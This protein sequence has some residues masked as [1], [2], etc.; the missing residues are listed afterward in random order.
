VLDLRRDEPALLGT[1]LEYLSR[2]NAETFSQPF[3]DRDL[4]P[5]G[6]PAFHTVSVRILIWIV[7]VPI[8]GRFAR[9]AP[10]LDDLPRSMK[11]SL[12]REHAHKRSQRR[13]ADAPTSSRR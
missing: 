4:P 2:C 3:R 12:A 1:K 7:N 5:L 6:H 11:T 13:L 10:G 8:R 9:Q